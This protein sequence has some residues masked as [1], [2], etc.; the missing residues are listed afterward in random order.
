VFV[1]VTKIIAWF[2]PAIYFIHQELVRLHEFEADEQSVK[3]KDVNEY[4]G[5]LSKIA[6]SGIGYPLGSHFAKSL[7]IKR[8]KLLP[9]SSR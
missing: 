8:I 3:D 1:N 5:L 2:H 4:C 9:A 7:T 6:L